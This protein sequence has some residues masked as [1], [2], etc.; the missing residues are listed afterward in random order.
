VRTRLDAIQII[1]K[2]VVLHIVALPYDRWI[3]VDAMFQRIFDIQRVK[4]PLIEGCA[5]D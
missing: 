4:W 1:R 2:L 5:D 3:I